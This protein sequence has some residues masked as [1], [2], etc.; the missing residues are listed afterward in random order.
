M[1]ECCLDDDTVVEINM[2]H[3]TLFFEMLEKFEMYLNGQG[4]CIKSH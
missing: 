1:D 2:R 3:F 4:R